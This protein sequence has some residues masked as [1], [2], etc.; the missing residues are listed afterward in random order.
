RSVHHVGW[1][2]ASHRSSPCPPVHRDRG[3]PGS[4][5]SEGDV[6]WS[7]ALGPVTPS[8]DTSLRQAVV[9]L[10]DLT[11]GRVTTLATKAGESVL[12]GSWAGSAQLTSSG[13][14]GHVTLGNLVTGQERHLQQQPG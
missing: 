5:A 4:Y 1:C 14:Q 6:L 10:K 3:G 12:A 7:Q 13:G 9:R 2:T 11:T 8:D